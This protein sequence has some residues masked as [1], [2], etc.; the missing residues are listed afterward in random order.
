MKI[1]FLII[2]AI[3]A[4]V[5]LTSG[6]TAGIAAFLYAVLAWLTSYVGLIPIAGVILYWA[7]MTYAVGPFVASFVVLGPWATLLFWIFF[8]ISLIYTIVITIVALAVV[9]A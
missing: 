4:I 7:I 2:L 5:A 3:T 9:L 6:L 1:L 8:V